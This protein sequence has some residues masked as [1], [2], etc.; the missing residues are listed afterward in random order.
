M[1]LDAPQVHTRPYESLGLGRHLQ[2]TASP[3]HCTL[4][5]DSIVNRSYEPRPTWSEQK[6][7]I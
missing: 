2:P 5:N 3:V 4:K 6:S 7:Q 1:S